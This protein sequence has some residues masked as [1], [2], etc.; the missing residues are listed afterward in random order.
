[1][2]WCHSPAE[3]HVPPPP[4]SPGPR[5]TAHVTLRECVCRI[6]HNNVCRSKRNATCSTFD[7]LADSLLG[8]DSPVTL[9]HEPRGCFVAYFSHSTC[10]HV[11]CGLLLYNKLSNKVFDTHTKK[12]VYYVIV[13]I[14]GV[15]I[16]KINYPPQGPPDP[17]K[18]YPLLFVHAYFV[19]FKKSM[20]YNALTSSYT[21]LCHAV[22]IRQQNLNVLYDYNYIIYEPNRPISRRL[23][24]VSWKLPFSSTDLR[25][26]TDYKPQSSLRGRASLR[27]DGPW[28]TAPCDRSAAEKKIK[29]TQL[30]SRRV[31]ATST[32]SGA[33]TEDGVPNQVR[34]LVRR[35]AANC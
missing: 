19:T 25:R 13:L 9:H 34:T 32:P 16:M 28:R 11:T 17:T 8:R 33:R 14:R 21:F 30:R 4:L 2:L 1:M 5:G 35:R 15:I 31:C 10:C 18:G 27:V 23:P 20:K 24:H 22:Q 3:R 29:K 26:F 7:R 12:Y 6:N